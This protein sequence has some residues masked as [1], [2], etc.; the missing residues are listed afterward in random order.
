MLR[1]T[2]AATALAT[3]LSLATPAHADVCMLTGKPSAE[4]A[5]RM[6]TAIDVLLRYCAP[7][8][9]TAPTRLK[10]SK[11]EAVPLAD[12]PASYQVRVNGNAE[13]TAYLYYRKPDGPTIWVNL[14]VM[15]GCAGESGIDLVELPPGL[16]EK[17]TTG[18]P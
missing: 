12:D 9:D 13:D 15:S 14:G 7:C 3:A 16:A 8:G 2:T 6:L 18:A 10:V 1:T 11:A 5:A 4:N 17:A